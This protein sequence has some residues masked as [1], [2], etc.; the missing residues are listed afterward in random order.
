M[1][2]I[3]TS[4]LLSSSSS[5]TACDLAQGAQYGLQIFSRVYFAAGL[6]IV[7][8]PITDVVEP[9]GDI[10]YI[11]KNPTEFVTSCEQALSASSSER[12]KMNEAYRN[13][14]AQ[15]S[16]ESTA[17]A[18]DNLIYQVKIRRGSDYHQPHLVPTLPT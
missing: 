3:H 4:G 16:W 8:T 12:A 9:Y 2:C 5:T 11:A 18:M 13:V 10:V 15:T 7:S 6:P 1:I 17:Q 14:L